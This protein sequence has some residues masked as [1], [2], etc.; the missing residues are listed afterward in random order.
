MPKTDEKYI[1][2]T[3]GSIRFIDKYQ[4]LSSSLDKLVKTLVNNSQ[5]TLK[6]LKKGI[7]DK[8]EILNFVTEIKILFKEDRYNKDCINVSKK[9]YLDK[10]GKLE[11]TLLNYIGENDLKILKT[12]FHDISGNF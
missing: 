3:H 9:D 5:R 2:V 1:R 6:T 7:D 10:I 8:D 11:E 4:F 12:A